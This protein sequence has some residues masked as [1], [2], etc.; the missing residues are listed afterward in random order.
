M[1]LLEIMALEVHNTSIQKNLKRGK[2]KWR[3]RRLSTVFFAAFHCNFH[4]MLLDAKQFSG[5]QE[6]SYGRKVRFSS[7]LKFMIYVLE[8]KVLMLCQKSALN[9]NPSRMLCSLYHIKDL[10]VFESFFIEVKKPAQAV[11]L[12]SLTGSF[13]IYTY[14][15]NPPLNV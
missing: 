14:F 9:I 13:L 8:N 3:V 6:G 2:N 12:I 5:K 15:E 7:S 1:A 11:V 4:C 10:I